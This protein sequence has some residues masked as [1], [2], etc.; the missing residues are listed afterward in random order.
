[1]TYL[2]FMYSWLVR[3]LLY[4]LSSGLN[5]CPSSWL[6]SLSS[7]LYEDYSSVSL[8]LSENE[9]SLLLKVESV[10]IDKSACICYSCSKQIKRSI[11]NNPNFQPRWKPKIVKETLKCSIHICNE[12]LCKTTKLASVEEIEEV[13][14]QKVAC[15]TVEDDQVAVGLCRDH[16]N[17]LYTTLHPPQDRKRSCRERVCQYV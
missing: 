1:M 17:T 12:K 14:Q 16:Y 4:R 3:L 2:V 5:T 9:Y 7:R 11:S 15:F 13:L 10:S 8:K 6:G